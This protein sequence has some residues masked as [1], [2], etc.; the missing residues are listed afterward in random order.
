MV[1]VLEEVDAAAPLL[2]ALG[3][4][5]YASDTRAGTNFSTTGVSGQLSQRA[6]RHL[7][8]QHEWDLM[9]YAWAQQRH[10][11]TL[12]AF[13][14]LRQAAAGAVAA[15]GGTSTHSVERAQ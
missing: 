14:Q 7:E 9:L 11:R 5:P 2:R 10:R 12:E 8:R 13:A 1:L 15:G 3:L 4:P 6:Q